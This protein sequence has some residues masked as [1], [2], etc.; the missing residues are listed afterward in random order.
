MPSKIKIVRNQEIPEIP[1][2]EAGEAR[3]ATPFLRRISS[4]N[5]RE[6]EIPGSKLQSLLVKQ[7][8]VVSATVTLIAGD[9]VGMTTT[10]TAYD[11]TV[12]RAFLETN[13]YVDYNA[14]LK[15]IF[16]DGASLT[17]SQ[18]ALEFHQTYHINSPTLSNLNSNQA[19]ASQILINGSGDTHTYYVYFRWVYFVLDQARTG[20]T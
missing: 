6:G 9:G 1:I 3:V 2:K 8:K 7:S 17:G 11:A 5:I 15:Y 12:I 4:E 19:K 16:A 18:R 10:L 14:D 13:I 20:A